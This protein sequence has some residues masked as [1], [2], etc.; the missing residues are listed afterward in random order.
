MV[1]PLAA[2]RLLYRA[3]F[4]ALAAGLI[5]V[6]ILPLGLGTGRL[7]SPDL[8]ILLLA[9]WALRRPDYVPTLLVAG[10][11]L[12][13]DILFMRPLGLWAALG[14]LGVEVLRSRGATSS[15]LPFLAEWLLVTV[16]LAA[17]TLAESVILAVL[18]VPRP[19]LGAAALHLVI[20][21]VVYPAAVLATTVIF[22]V[23]P[24]TPADRD[25]L[26]A[27]S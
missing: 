3:L 14:L 18:M 19:P 12:L 1:D 17:M 10:V 9:A 7:P 6:Q 5:F 2:R 16:V 26:A 4:A 22:G 13:S 20:S 11:L 24:A 25:A 27:R 8:L 21:A 15:E 23:R